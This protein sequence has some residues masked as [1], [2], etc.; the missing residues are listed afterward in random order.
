MTRWFVGIMFTILLFGCTHTN[1]LSGSSPPD[2]FVMINEKKYETVLGT[3]CWNSFGESTC[4]DT[5][6]PVELLSA[7]E[8][9]KV[10]PGDIVTFTM[11]YDPMPNEIYVVQYYNDAEQEVEVT[12]H[13]F[14]VPDEQGV[15]Y[16]SYG[17]WWMDEHHE[18]LSHGDAFYNFVLEVK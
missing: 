13:Q 15:Y 1:V 2:A 3:Y 17:V 4:V 11:D 8:P 10:K 5:V 12:N 7:H 18:H 16:Y 14:Q 6:G 9:I